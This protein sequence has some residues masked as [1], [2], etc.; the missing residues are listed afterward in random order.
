M[1]S[2]A[3][4][5]MAALTGLTQL[6]QI[7]LPPIELARLGQWAESRV[8]G[9]QTGLLDQLTS[10]CG[11]GDH[12]LYTDFRSL[13]HKTI[14]LPPGWVFVAIDSGVKH[15]LTQDYNERR[16]SCEAAAAAMGIETL[17]DTSADLLEEHRG[18]MTDDAYRC[19]THI[20]GENQRVRDANDALANGD[21]QHLGQLMFASHDSSRDHFRNSCP[22]LD[23]LVDF[24][25]QDERCL[26]SRL[27]GGGFGGITIHLTRMEDAEAYREDVLQ[28]VCKHH[29]N[30]AW[31]AVCQVDDGAF[32][33]P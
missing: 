8:V 21:L 18:D 11:R 15:D 17:R 25:R 10:F 7:E 16:A 26:G 30:R 12:L 20:A 32:I 22:S 14:P 3:A 24:A 33:L 9:A 1:S 6:M 27:S 13:E 4:L 23:R 29:E 5:E 2:S 19:A 28:K 31:S